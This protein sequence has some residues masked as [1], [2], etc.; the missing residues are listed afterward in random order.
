MAAASSLL[1]LRA[2]CCWSLLP[3]TCRRANARRKITGNR[4]Y[5]GSASLP[6]AAGADS[7]GSEEV[8]I[9]KRKIWDNVAV[10]QALA[11]TLQRDPTAAHYTFQDDPFL[12]PVSS[13]EA[14][15]F[16]LARDSGKNAARYVINTYPKFFEKDIAEPHIPCL[17]P[18]YVEPQLED[19]SEAALQERIRLRRVRA[20]VDMFDHLLQEG[21]SVSLETTNSLLDLLCYYGDQEPPRE[22]QPHQIDESEELEEAQEKLTKKGWRRKAVAQSGI[23]WRTNNNAERIF[24]LMPE[25]NAHSY[26][27]MIRGMVKYQACEKAFK[28]YTDLLNNRLSAD[29]HTFNALIEASASVRDRYEEKWNLIL[30]L[31]KQMIEQKV[32]PNLQTF[33]AILRT[34]RKMGSFG[35]IPALQTLCEMKALEIEPSLATYHYILEIFY[36]VGPSVKISP[37]QIADILRELKGKKLCAQDLDDDKFFPS[38]MKVCFML[39]DLDLAYQVHG[40]VRTGDNWKL[41]GDPFQSLFYYQKFFSLLCLMEQIDVTLK[42]YKELIPSVCFPH[43]YLILNLL[44]ALDV[45]NR[46]EMIPEIWKDCKE[47]GLSKWNN[48]R[49]EILELMAR[50]KH[51]PEVQEAF[52]NCAAD[53]KSAYENEDGSKLVSEWP[54]APMNCI[55]L[56]LLR[57]GRTREAWQMLEY[58]KKQ[59]KIPRTEL[60]NEFM[61]SAKEC[62]NSA[63]AV[64]LVELAHA[65]SLAICEPLTQRV[66][67]DFEV[68]EEQKKALEALSVTTSDSE[69]SDSGSNSSSDS[70]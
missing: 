57:G 30:D 41:I 34:L 50:E 17:M 18:E 22:D 56:L 4:V 38:A 28:T 46:L 15:M 2:G 61:D 43:S 9:P 69:S 12:T 49:E 6:E 63:Q 29:V 53:I 26:C 58:F 20:S 24:N 11:S 70:E 36:K 31:L 65:L 25:K 59:N 8:V 35:K 62:H 27:T 67:A 23:T 68:S 40:L 47:F 37:S 10:L 42:W 32:K 7:P 54:S 21:T 45:G 14:R 51:P 3:A 66:L 16:L 55:T 5:S 44:Q 60:M 52:A 13:S 39:K 48:V 64:H 19:R 1:F 33:N